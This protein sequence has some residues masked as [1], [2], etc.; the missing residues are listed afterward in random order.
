MINLNLQ[1]TTGIY[2]KT[3]DVYIA[4]VKGTFFGPKLVKFGKTEIETGGQTDRPPSQQD[5]AIAA[6]IRKV[7]QENNITTNKVVTALAG[8]DVL[9]RYFQMPRIPRSEWETAI[10][11]EAKKYIPFKIEELIWDSHVVLAGDKAAKMDVTFV[12]VK[13]DVSR[14][15]IALLEESGLKTSVLEPAPFSL[16]RLFALGNQ[17]AKDKAT[18]IIDVDYGMA[19]INI[20]KDKICYLTRDVTLPLEEEMVFESLLNE[21]RMSL[22]YYEKLFPAEVIGKILLCGEVELKDWD[23][24]LTQELKIPVEK[25]DPV[26]AIKFKDALPPLSMATAIGLAL[27]G[28]VK[29]V[30]D[31]NLFRPPEEAIPVERIK[32]GIKFTPELRQAIFRAVLLSIVGLLILYSVMHY[33]VMQEKKRLKQVISLQPRIDLP[34]ASLSDL[35]IEEIK[36]K[37]EKKLYSLDLIIDKRIFWTAKFNELPNLVPPGLWLTY[38]SFSEDLSRDNKISRFLTIKGI[39]YHENPV[40]EIGIVTKFVSNLKENWA[41]SEGFKEIK[42]D[43]MTSKELNGM[44]V[45]SFTVSC[46][47]RGRD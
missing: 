36:E 25:A 10:K 33:R 37:L 47:G 32:E 24:V 26:K 31:V 28:L 21:I 29:A 44:P 5:E 13:K 17:L 15:H 9:I 35:K 45:K 30:P 18:V 20:V 11:F 3:K 8:K 4:Q 38:L 27:R 34:I 1:S 19:D 39:A 23:R 7:I 16:I 42:L 6:A 46:S 2:I 14:R 43:S 12:A 40:R 22:E 41:F